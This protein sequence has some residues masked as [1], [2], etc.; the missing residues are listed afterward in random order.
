MASGFGS[1]H[2]FT[3][4]LLEELGVAD[5]QVTQGWG[6]VKASAGTHSKVGTYQGVPFGPCVDLSYALADQDFMARLWQAGFV[7]FV[8]N[9]ASGWSGSCHIHAVCLGLVDD[10]GHKHLPPIVQTQC[11]DF[12]ASPPKSGLM[13]HHHLTGKYI[14][15]PQMQANL[16]KQYQAWWPGYATRVLSPEGHAIPCSAALEGDTVTAEVVA[17][18]NFWDVGML[19][20]PGQVWDGRFW[21][22]PIRELAKATKLSVASFAF[23]KGKTAAT[24]RLAYA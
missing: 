6:T 3:V 4:P 22:A 11:D 16:R 14:P 8:R 5:S 12:L 1:L 9:A 21:R 15:T 13:G 10:A 19:V 18:E 2:P 7:A 24:V 23:N 20:V 17:W